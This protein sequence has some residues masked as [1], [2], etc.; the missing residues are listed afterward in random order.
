MMKAEN[1]WT[2]LLQSLFGG[3]AA[4]Q[5]RRAQEEERVLRSE[6][7]IARRELEAAERYFQ[8]V[9]DPELVDHAI[10]SMEAARRKYLYLY[11]RLRHGYGSAPA[12]HAVTNAG[13]EPAMGIEPTARANPSGT[14]EEAEWV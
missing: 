13:L 14:T 1:Q 2:G 12:A 10:Y 8:T 11:R 4:V 6:M 9:T 3:Q 5:A 7:E